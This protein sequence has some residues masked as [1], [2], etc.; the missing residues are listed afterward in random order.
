[1]AFQVAS[2]SALVPRDCCASHRPAAA[3]SDCHQDV[4]PPPHCPMAAAEGAPCPMHVSEAP[5]PQDDCVMRG[6]CNGPMAALAVLLPGHGI[7]AEPTRCP[8]DLPALG[9]V[10]VSAETAFDRARPPDPPPPHA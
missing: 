8:P 3:T 2:L 1:M 7:L 10:D 6:S 5:S 4:A 9:R